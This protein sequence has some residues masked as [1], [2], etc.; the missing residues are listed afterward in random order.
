MIGAFLIY[1]ENLRK[2]AATCHIR[3][4]VPSVISRHAL[5]VQPF[6]ILFYLKNVA[7]YATIFKHF[8]YFFLIHESRKNNLKFVWHQCVTRT[9]RCCPCLPPPPA[10]FPREPL[11]RCR[12]CFPPLSRHVDCVT[13]R[14]RVRVIIRVPPKL[15]HVSAKICFPPKPGNLCIEAQPVATPNWKQP[16]CLA[17]GEQRAKLWRMVPQKTT[18]R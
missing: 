11:T 9:G 6:S 4:E 2:H 13:V 12:F 17:R 18:Q 1:F 7:R 14:D 15:L 16:H 8:I 10:T 5:I 3:K